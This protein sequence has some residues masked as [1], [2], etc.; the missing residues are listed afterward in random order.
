MWDQRRQ[1]WADAVQ[2]LYK[3]FVFAGMALGY[4]YIL[5]RIMNLPF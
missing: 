1:C 5:A 2:M 3:C 4:G